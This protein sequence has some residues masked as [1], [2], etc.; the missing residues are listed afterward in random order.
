M[1]FLRKTIVFWLCVLATCSVPARADDQALFSRF[2][3]DPVQRQHVLDAAKRS[4]V[5]LNNPCPSAEFAING[6]VAIHTPP[7]F[8][9]SEQPIS[10][11]WKEEVVEKGCN[12]ERLLNVYLIFDPNNKSLAVFPVLPGTS[13]TD[14]ILQKD[15]QPHVAAAALKPQ[16]QACNT[17]YIAD[18]EFIRQKGEALQG[19]KGKPWDELWTMVICDKKALI[20]MHFIPDKAGTAI[21][22]SPAETKFLP[23]K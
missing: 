11:A 5:V 10:G 12:L 20:T 7:Q 13:R 21:V 22:A 18:T 9:N 17:K 6:K 23:N 3:S 2:L 16:D 15:A 14:L 4:S 19:A 1:C 8:D